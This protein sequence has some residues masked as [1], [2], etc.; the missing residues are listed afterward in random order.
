MP[1]AEE[2]SRPERTDGDRK[3]IAST[4]LFDGQTEVLILHNGEQYR[5]RVTR[6]D[7]LILTK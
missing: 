1:V 6:Q 3:T 2:P 4:E 5:L 7:K